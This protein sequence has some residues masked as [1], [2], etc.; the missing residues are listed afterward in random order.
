[1]RDNSDLPYVAQT[2]EFRPVEA[3]PWCGASEFVHLAKRG[4]DLEVKRCTACSLGF[5]ASV[6]DDLSVFYDASYYRRN[7]TVGVEPPR[8]GYENYESTYT[9]SS[10]RWLAALVAAIAPK[11]GRLFDFGAATG[12]FLEMA[13]FEGFDVAGSEL[14]HE[15][16]A[17][18]Q[19]LGLDVREGF[20]VPSEWPLGTFDVVTAF[21]VLEHVTDIRGTLVGLRELLHED[22]ILVFSV[23]NVVDHIFREFGDDA[24]DFNKSYEHTLYFNPDALETIIGEIFG[25]D[26]LTLHTAES[27]IWDQQVSSALGVV[28]MSPTSDRTEQRLLRAI[29]GSCP[30][31]E[32]TSREEAVAVALAA[33]RFAEP[34]VADAA[35]DRA[36]ECGSTPADLATVRAQVLRNRG[37]IYNAF[38]CLEAQVSGTVGSSDPLVAPLLLEIFDDLKV[39]LGI[40][41]VGF[42]DGLQRLHERLEHLQHRVDDVDDL[43]AGEPESTHAL[44]DRDWF[45]FKREQLAEADRRVRQAELEARDLQ[46]LFAESELDRIEAV[47]RAD[48]LQNR[49]ETYA[50]R[51]YDIHHSRMWKI[52]SLLWRIKAIVLRRP[53]AAADD[54]ESQD[55]TQSDASI[56]Q[57]SKPRT[58]PVSV[59][60]IMP[61][62]NK[63]STIRDSIDSLLAQTFP[64]IEIVVWDDGSTDAATHEALAEIEQLD[65]VTVTRAEN[66]GVVGAR[67]SAMQSARGEF[68]VCLD[69]DDRFEPT[70]IEKAVAYLRSS[71]G[72]SI[73]YPWQRTVGS[74]IEV[75]E[76]NQ[77][78]PVAIIENNHVPVCA[79]FRREVFEATG[80]FSEAMAAG[81]EDWEFWAHAASLGFQ[82]R[83]IPEPLFEY[84][85]SNDPTKSRD[86]EARAA[87]DELS[88]VIRK[89]HATDAPPATKRLPDAPRW[90][91]PQVPRFPVSEGRPVLL[92]L[93]WFTV[94]GADTVVANL[95]EHWR[96][97]GRTV[98]V[99]TTLGA[100]P[101]MENRLSDLLTI[102]PFVYELPNYLPRHLWYPFVRSIATALASPTILN[103][104]STWFYD[105]A[106]RL[107]TD[108]PDIR[109][110]DQQFN[111]SGH[112][113][114]N[115]RTRGV[116]DMTVTAYRG[117]QSSIDASGHA[118]MTNIYVGIDPKGVTTAEIAAVR[119]DI[120]IADSVRFVTFVGRLSEEKRPEWILPV[121]DALDRHGYR[122]VVVGQGPLAKKHAKSFERHPAV[123]WRPIIENPLALFAAADATIL[124]SRIEGI[125]LTAMESLSVGTPV[126]AT[127]VGGL[128]ELR[129]VSGVHLVD[130][131]DRDAF[132]E[133][134]LAVLD[135]PPSDGITL[136]DRLSLEHM[137]HEYDAAVEGSP[138]RGNQP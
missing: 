109:I 126:V 75:W 103:I 69:P 51:L 42:A 43:R 89:R 48:E 98:V 138:P 90:I 6:P 64:D 59:S 112:V 46:Y 18:A 97:Q 62:Y 27:T 56:T 41:E 107:K 20:F 16:A 94:G 104:G 122:V 9:P 47:A 38:R 26:R 15:G 22:G 65:T 40:D 135:H 29:S 100:G 124:P 5:L 52:W 115:R 19:A 134:S 105:N 121:A 10:F 70:Y 68:F 92:M 133:S 119:S 60:V 55:S 111:D 12:S 25:P 123:I 83:A 129:D 131:D 113:D 108:L 13:R 85:Y 128:P 23:P 24:I 116:I 88:Q 34:D 80:G 28:R 130:P 96:S 7:P 78:D 102:T 136:P 32:L 118:P 77:L 93:P 1:M 3:C 72:V 74:K 63:G 57:A 81:Y 73:V 36:V 66:Q 120:G 110:V 30:V 14:T 50:Q 35:L 99:V 37:E 137:L 84:S 127:A 45:E 33:A 11:R 31:E 132:V 114:G 44:T 61:V 2:N 54:E 8:S 58:F 101:D 71:P 17:A 91:E 86:A 53:P 95:V 4:D 87:K 39:L 82:G 76:T 67:N 117:L 79:L 49:A 106:V 125:P 21:E